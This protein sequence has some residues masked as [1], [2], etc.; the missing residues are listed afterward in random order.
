[1]RF[2]KFA[3][4]VIL[5]I[6]LTACGTSS[7]DTNGTP[8][9][10]DLIVWNRDPLAV[11]FRADVVGGD[12]S[13][14][15]LNNTVP[16]CTIYGDGRIVWRT[17]G[18]NGRSQVLFDILDDDSMISFVQQLVVNYR[19]YTYDEGY[20]REAPQSVVPVYQQFVLE[21]N[22]VRHIGDSFSGWDGLYFTELME[23][24]KTF[25]P[26]P[27]IFEPT[28]AWVSAVPAGDNIN[29][30]TV[31]WDST[32]AGFSFWSMAEA[33]D[34]RWVEGQGVLFLWDNVILNTFP[35][36]FDDN[37]GQF[38]VSMQVP[39]VTLDAPVAPANPVSIATPA[40]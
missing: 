15:Q 20:L 19:I 12:R 31:I 6:T 29:A 8:Q 5:G 1:M 35:V 21:V 40:Q 18:A 14:T 34:K 28:G 11:V 2:F 30:Y 17:E 9:S 4:M 25:A 32:A 7:T 22:G 16:E 36:Y 38:D 24:C 10:G 13:V 27:R 23:F 39:G 37:V 3:I 26:A 33:G